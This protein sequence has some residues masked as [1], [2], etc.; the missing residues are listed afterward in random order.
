MPAIS[1]LVINA[2]SVNDLGTCLMRQLKYP[3]SLARMAPLAHKRK[4]PDPQQNAPPPPPLFPVLGPAHNFHTPYFA[5]QLA[6]AVPDL[7]EGVHSC[8][9]PLDTPAATAGSI[10]YGEMNTF[11]FAFAVRSRTATRD[12]VWLGPKSRG[13]KPRHVVLRFGMQY[14]YSFVKL[15]W[16]CIHTV[17]QAQTDSALTPVPIQTA[18]PRRV[19][20]SAKGRPSSVLSTAMR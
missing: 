5:C 1:S 6:C 16:Y 4:A 7:G 15:A 2:I 12:P 20:P 11:F 10:L 14:M 3:S 13:R 18:F 17:C 19:P 9:F 8:S